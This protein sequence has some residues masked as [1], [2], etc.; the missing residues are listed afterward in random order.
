M[1]AAERACV[2]RRA[3]LEQVPHQGSLH[4]AP[5]LDG[6][7]PAEASAQAV[8]SAPGVTCALVG[9]RQTRHVAEMVRAATRPLLDID[10]AVRALTRPC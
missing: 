8:R 7:T 10:D 1:T 2:E 9:M 5:I 6:L 3:R 4:A